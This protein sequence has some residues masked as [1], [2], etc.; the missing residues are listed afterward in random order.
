MPPWISPS[1]RLRVLVTIA[2]SLAI[3]MNLYA[4]ELAACASI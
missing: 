1:V 2:A 3:I 4:L